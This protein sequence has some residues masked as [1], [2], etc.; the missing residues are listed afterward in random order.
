[1][2]DDIKFGYLTPENV[3]TVKYGDQLKIFPNPATHMLFLNSA[4]TIQEFTISNILGSEV[5]RSLPGRK[6]IDVDVS[7]FPAGL[8]FI[9]TSDGLVQ[10]FVKE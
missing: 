10:K 1:M 2:I 6:S 8:Y 9:R 7:N 4:E 5:F 3:T